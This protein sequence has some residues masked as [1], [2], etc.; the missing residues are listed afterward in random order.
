ARRRAAANLF[1][2]SQI[3]E[4][5]R[6]N[7]VSTLAFSGMSTPENGSQRRRPVVCVAK[8]RARGMPTQMTYRIFFQDAK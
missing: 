8:Y 3:M 7:A 4:A 5:A 6:A 1:T 2:T